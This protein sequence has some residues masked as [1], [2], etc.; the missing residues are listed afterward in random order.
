[1]CVSRVLHANKVLTIVLQFILKSDPCGLGSLMPIFLTWDPI[2]IPTHSHASKPLKH[3]GAGKPFIIR[4]QTIVS[5]SKLQASVQPLPIP[6]QQNPHV[7]S[8][9]ISSRLHALLLCFPKSDAPHFL[10]GRWHGKA[11]AGAWTDKSEVELRNISMF[12]VQSYEEYPSVGPVVISKRFLP[13][14]LA[15]SLA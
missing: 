11:Q 9:R 7:R 1:M 12:L 10:L 4:L 14:P 6:T 15:D 13:F 2:D 5:H 3:S 8:E